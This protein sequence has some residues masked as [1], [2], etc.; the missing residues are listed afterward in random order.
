MQEKKLWYTAEKRPVY[1]NNIYRGSSLFLCCSGPSLLQH[2]L[3]LISGMPTFA[4][5]NAPIALRRHGG[6]SP[7]FWTMTDDVG[8]FCASIYEDPR[9]LKFLPD[10][11]VNHKIFDNNKWNRQFP[12]GDCFKKKKIKDC[13]GVLYYMRPPKERE[14]FDANTFLQGDEFCWGN[15]AQRCHC[16][17]VRP[18]DVKDKL[19][20]EC[21]E[22]KNWGSRSCML[23][24]VRMAYELGF[25]KVFLLGCDFTMSKEEQNYA[26]EQ[27][28]AAG[29]V[30]NNNNTYRMLNMRFDALKPV[31]DRAGFE[32]YNCFEGSGLKSFPY[33]PFAECVEMAYSYPLEE[34]THGLYDRKANEKQWKK[35]QE[36]SEK[37]QQEQAAL[38]GKPATLAEFVEMMKG[39]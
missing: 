34:L 13:P 15:W 11:K 10:G 28:R 25:R 22:R 33:K 35:Q 27:E 19:C 30:R 12:S 3:S 6:F 29:A 8:N 16:G 31:F 17:Y 23:V 9:I 2:N 39:K 14:F 38:K 32:V 5:N 26:F 20:P 21:G 37:R 36:E 4:V 18:E 1:L 24:A 7:T